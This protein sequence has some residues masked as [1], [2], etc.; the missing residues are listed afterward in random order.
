MKSDDIAALADALAKA[1]GEIKNAAFNRI[2]P[3]FKNRYADLAAVFDALRGPFSK[4][5]LAVTQTTEIRDG[6]MI[7]VTTVAHSSG[8]WF[9][10][11]YP[12]PSTA[13]P[14]ELGSA[15]T[16]ARRYSLSAIAGIAADDDD[17]AET[18]EKAVAK[19]G[20][21]H[22]SKI[23]EQ[24]V[25]TLQSAIV[26]VGADISKFLAYLKVECLP[27]L[28]SNKYDAAM[29]ALEAKRVRQ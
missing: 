6:G 8:Q 29:A 18:A 9:K 5:Q 23:T 28:P 20:N 24:Q 2:N 21:G 3:H 12:L 22:N 13:R 11:E 7:L 25:E 17:D 4:N 26:E 19:N 14:Q 27:D 16:Y 15:L 1:Q 10:S